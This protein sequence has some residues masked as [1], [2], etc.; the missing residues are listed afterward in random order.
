LKIADKIIKRIRDTEPN[1][2]IILLGSLP[3]RILGQED[4][5][6]TAFCIKSEQEKHNPVFAGLY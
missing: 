4:I 3:L 6:I 5:D 2:E 1:P